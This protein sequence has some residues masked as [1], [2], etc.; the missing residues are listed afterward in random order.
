MKLGYARVSTDPQE[1]FAE[2]F[3]EFFYC[4]V[5]AAGGSRSTAHRCL[6]EWWAAVERAEAA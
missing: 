2:A 3:A 5:I 6:A 1:Q 4:A